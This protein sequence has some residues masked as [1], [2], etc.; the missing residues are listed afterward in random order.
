MPTLYNEEKP[1]EL[2]PGGEQI[3]TSSGFSS[4]GIS[5]N[6]PTQ[7]PVKLPQTEFNKPTLNSPT[8][9]G[10][11]VFTGGWLR[12]ANFVA[13]VSGWEI[14]AEGNV[15][16]QD[17]TIRGTL[18]ALLGT[19]GG[20]TI[21]STTLT[22]GNIVLDQ[23]NNKITVGASPNGI[24]INGATGKITSADGTTWTLDGDGIVV[25]FTKF[26]GTGADGALSI[27][28]G[29]TTINCAGAAVV[30]KNYTSISITGTG[31]LAFSNPHANGTVIILK[32]QGAVTLTSSATPMIDASAMGAAG[33][34][35]VAVSYPTNSN[36]NNG[37]VGLVNLIQTNFGIK[38]T[39]SPPAG[40]A[41]GAL[42]TAFSYKNPTVQALYKYCFINVGGGGASG[43]A[44][45]SPMGSGSA[46]SGA[47]GNGGGG[48]IIECGGA[49]NFTTTSGISVAGGAGGNGS[50]SPAGNRAG[51]GGG[52]GGGHCLAFYN[53]LTA[54][55][56]TITIAGGSGVD[57]AGGGGG[58][59]SSITAGNNGTDPTGGTGGAG[60]SLVAANTEF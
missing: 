59:A 34:A 41:G 47:G 55:S 31:Q 49:W 37:T 40:G 13:G 24:I 16:F 35:A 42:P 28:S 19:I 30:V 58:G 8:M 21:G 60:F 32:S 45:S 4:D 14:N 18:Y 43:S 26:G 20:W 3:T 5:S 12:S 36:G 1:D 57:T 23:A 22:G 17:A 25:G 50:A 10:N 2:L 51:G 9:M 48:L 46:T 53:T 33:G 56:G 29:T 44:Q 7:T 15:E 11:S 54:N 27:T 52:G 39:Q 6:T 38:G